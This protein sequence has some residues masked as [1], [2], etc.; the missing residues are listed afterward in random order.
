[1]ADSGHRLITIK[2]WY[3]VVLPKPNEESKERIEDFYLLLHFDSLTCTR[4]PKHP[5]GLWPHH[6]KKVPPPAT[7]WRRRWR[8][9]WRCRR[10]RRQTHQR[11]L[12]PI[13]SL[14]GFA[15]TLVVA[16]MLCRSLYCCL[17]CVCVFLTMCVAVI[18]AGRF[19]VVCCCFETMCVA[20]VFCGGWQ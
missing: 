6:K 15:L 7:K 12:E 2:T 3:D 10:R 16:E 19:I 1:M 18:C 14:D 20:G 4:Y 5:L 17:L 9:S 13:C 8:R 11:S